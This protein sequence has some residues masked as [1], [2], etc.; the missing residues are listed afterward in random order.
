LFIVFI[1]V[2]LLLLLLL[3]RCFTRVPFQICGW[4]DHPHCGLMFACDCH[5]FFRIISVFPTRQWAT[6]LIDMHHWVLAVALV[7]VNPE[8]VDCESFDECTIVLD[9]PILPCVRGR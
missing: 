2:T 9:F 1:S 3:L 7:L 6:F 5:S 4:V 8:E